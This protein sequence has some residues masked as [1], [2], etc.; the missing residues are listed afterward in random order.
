MVLGH[1]YNGL[2]SLW[3]SPSRIKYSVVS[4][5]LIKKKLFNSQKTRVVQILLFPEIIDSTVQ[6]YNNEQ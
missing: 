5:S 1:C 6:G 4:S 3:V 2:I